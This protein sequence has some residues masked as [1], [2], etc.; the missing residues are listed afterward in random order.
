MSHSHKTYITGCIHHPD[1]FTMFCH[2][3]LVLKT[4]LCFFHSMYVPLPQNDFQSHFKVWL[5][6]SLKALFFE[7]SF[8]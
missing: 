5:I 4:C 7:S 1:E 8:H 6:S 3:V 2:S